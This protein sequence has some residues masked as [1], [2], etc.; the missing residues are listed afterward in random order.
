MPKHK[1]DYSLDLFEPAY[2][3][4]LDE[5]YHSHWAARKRRR[6]DFL[7]ETVT[8]F[9]PRGHRSRFVHV[10]GTNGKGSVVHYLEQG[11][12]AVTGSWTGPH[13]F[14]YKER[15]H[16]NGKM[17]ASDEITAVYREKLLPSI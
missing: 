1:I 4:T 6:I 5:I 13:V 9:W 16:I 14:D 12:P 17:V 15:F 2:L 10:T 7:R 3:V 11:F 8:D